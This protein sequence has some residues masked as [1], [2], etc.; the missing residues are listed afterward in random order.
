MA[1]TKTVSAKPDT[2]RLALA[3]IHEGSTHF[4]A[5]RHEAARESYTR[6]LAQDPRQLEAL[7]G[8]GLALHALGRDAEALPDFDAALGIAPEDESLWHN[9]GISLLRIDAKDDALLAFG[10]ALELAPDYAPAAEGGAF[11]ALTLKRFA[12]TVA[13]CDHLLAREPTNLRAL[14]LRADA[15][16]ETLHYKEALCFYDLALQIAP[17]D[18]GLWV[19]RSAALIGLNRRGDAYESAQRAVALD[20]SALSWRALGGAALKLSR[21]DEA[22]THFEQALE[23]APGDADAHCGVAIARKELGD[24]EGALSGFDATLAIDPA[25]NEAK[26][27]KGSLLMLLGRY[28]EGLPLFEYR[29]LRGQN[30]RADVQLPWPQWQGEDLYGKRLLILDEAGLGDVIQYAR[31]LPLLAQE[32]G[33]AGR[34]IYACRRPMRALLDANFGRMIDI[35]VAPEPGEPTP[36]GIDIEHFDLC[37]PLCSIPLA[38]GTRVATIPSPGRYLEAD[39]ERV[40]HWRAKIGAHGFRIG[41]A[42]RGS[43]TADSDDARAAPLAAFA[44]L[45]ALPGVRL[46]SLQMNK[47]AEETTDCGF[48]VETLGADF[49]AGADAFLDSAAVMDSLDLVV[50]IDTSLAHLAGALGRPLW[51]ALKNVPEWRWLLERTDNPWHPSARLFRQPARGDW[52]SVVAN[53]AAALELLLES[54]TAPTAQ[55]LSLPGSIGELFDRMTILELKEQHIA[56]AGKL[57]NVRR[58]LALLRGSERALELGAEPIEAT[59]AELAQVNAALWRIEDDIRL[60]EQAGDFG[61]R[62]IEL[63]RSVYVQNDRRAALKYRLNA[64]C[65]SA[66]V[67]EKSY[68]GAGGA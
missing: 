14:W 25:H 62:F 66:V 5:G 45:A 54:R 26:G 41:L 61:P 10:R 16:R 4:L 35:I 37:I 30:T 34:V 55:S 49:D 7:R 1:S 38:F 8:R 33:P 47:G 68:A 42:W 2:S 65:G 57:A 32:A 39:P 19:S 67:E 60:C 51:V 63:A 23:R 28:Q 56:D 11:A 46:I 20:D 18:A 6:A 59:R 43:A 58:E 17:D 53:M 22:L 31:Y 15:L 36:D 13:F 44:P 9:L 40:A 27:N 48:P 29:W 52:T 3:F 21:Y 64:L 12:R 24:L 50:S